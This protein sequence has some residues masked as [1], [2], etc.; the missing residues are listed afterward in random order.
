MN[1]HRQVIIIVTYYAT[2][3]AAEIGKWVLLVSHVVTTINYNY[4]L[5]CYT[6]TQLTIL[7]ANIP[8]YSPTVFITHLTSSHIHTSKSAR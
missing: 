4:L 2:E 6:F 7:H 3:D 1:V 5:R 8:F